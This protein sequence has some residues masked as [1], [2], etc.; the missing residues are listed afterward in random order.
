[1]AGGYK[2]I[3]HI[4]YIYTG[5]SWKDADHQDIIKQP[6]KR[7]TEAEL[8]FEQNNPDLLT[9]RRAF[10][11]HDQ[12]HACESDIPA[13]KASADS[14]QRQSF[15]KAKGSGHSEWKNSMRWGDVCVC[16]CEEEEEMCVWGGGDVG[17][18]SWA[19]RASLWNNISNNWHKLRSAH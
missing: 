15:R 10:L 6:K 19:W 5:L 4:V 17:G 1:M 12:T 18:I 16:V 8:T 7:E 9:D 3:I 14:F 2:I 11:H 13:F